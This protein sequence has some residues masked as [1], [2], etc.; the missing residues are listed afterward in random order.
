VQYD[1]SIYKEYEEANEQGVVMKR[2]GMCLLLV[3]KDNFI[4]WIKKAL[5]FFILQSIRRSKSTLKEEK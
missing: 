4:R 2:W 1:N 5:P 3:S